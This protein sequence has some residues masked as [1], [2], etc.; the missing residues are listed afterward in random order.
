[1]R[2]STAVTDIVTPAVRSRMMSNIRGHDTLPERY[3]RRYLHAAGLRYRLQAKHLPGRP[4]I[5]FPALKIAIF[6]HGCFWHQHPGCPDA[7]TPATR[8]AYWQAKFSAN[9]SRDD[10]AAQGLEQRGWT[11]F[12]VWECQANRELELDQLVWSIFA[13]AD[14]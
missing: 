10:A 13:I 14:R 12:T 7:S 1:M 11:V 2:V 5:V 4:D 8:P 3:V 6:V 9:R